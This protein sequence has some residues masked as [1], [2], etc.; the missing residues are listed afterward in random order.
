MTLGTG[1]YLFHLA[2][3]MKDSF[4]SWVLAVVAAFMVFVACVI[5]IR[6]LGDK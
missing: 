2:N 5:L 4:A 1:L 3:G 6:D